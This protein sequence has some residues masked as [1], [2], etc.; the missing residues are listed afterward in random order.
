MSECTGL[1]EAQN[2]LLAAYGGTGIEAISRELTA[3]DNPDVDPD[4][5]PQ[6]LSGLPWWTM[7][8]P[9]ALKYRP[10]FEK[11]WEEG[12]ADGVNHALGDWENAPQLS[13]I[14]TGR[15]QKHEPQTGDRR[16]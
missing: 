12:F 2:Q 6:V 7:K 15:S 14:R 9:Q 1:S 16:G 4:F 3:V 11:A 10:L 13:T 8:I 5:R